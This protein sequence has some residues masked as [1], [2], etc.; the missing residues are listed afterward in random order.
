[1]NLDDYQALAVATLGPDR[2]PTLLALGICGEAGEV[3]D[4]L[5]AGVSPVP[6]RIAELVKKAHRPGRDINL[7]LLS[8]EI[9]D[10][11]W[12]L[13]CLAKT[14]DLNLSD[15]AVE[16]IEKLHERYGKPNE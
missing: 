5:H 15:I 11:L 3:A 9:G 6:S 8:K 13:A 14:Y 1:M 16:N 4:E 2:H 7:E 12:Y 10:E